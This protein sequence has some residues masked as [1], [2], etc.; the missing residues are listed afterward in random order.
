MASDKKF[1][2][3]SLYKKIVSEYDK[4]MPQSQTANPWH[5]EEEPHNNN[6]TPGRQTQQCNQLIYLVEFHSMMLHTKY[7]CYGPSGSRLEDFEKLFLS[8]VTKICNGPE[9]FN[10]Y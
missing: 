5:R 6:E 8:S 4:E 7:Q 9:P 3:S 1:F 10:N 2:M